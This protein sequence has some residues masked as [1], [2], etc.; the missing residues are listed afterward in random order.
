MLTHIFNDYLKERNS[1]ASAKRKSAATRNKTP[2]LEQQGERYL[3]FQ[4]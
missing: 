4:S 2:E 3:F 1:G